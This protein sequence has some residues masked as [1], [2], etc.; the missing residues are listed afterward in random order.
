MNGAPSALSFASARRQIG[1]VWL[2]VCALYAH[3]YSVEFCY[4]DTKNEWLF[5]ERGVT[6]EDAI[7]AISEGN[8]IADFEHPDQQRYPGQRLLVIKLQEYPYCVPYL[9]NGEVMELKTLYPSRKFK[10]LLEEDGDE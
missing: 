7:I 3:N 9:N 2:T 5:R 4:D 1:G 6:F 10:Y 8:L